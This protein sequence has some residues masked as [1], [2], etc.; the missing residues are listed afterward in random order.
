MNVEN[1]KL[2]KNTIHQSINS[3]IYQRIYEVNLTQTTHIDDHN[4]TNYRNTGRLVH[5]SLDEGGS[6]GSLSA[7]SARVLAQ[8]GETVGVSAG[9]QHCLRR[10]DV[11]VL[12]QPRLQ[13]GL[14]QSASVGEGQRPGARAG[15]VVDLAQGEGRFLL[16][17]TAGQEGDAGD[18]AG[19]SV[20]R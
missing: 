19:H 1:T 16:G 15:G 6:V 18:G 7:S 4:L 3:K 5:I 10:G 11:G 12:S 14:L 13:A 2:L 8:V 17:H 9:Q 20:L